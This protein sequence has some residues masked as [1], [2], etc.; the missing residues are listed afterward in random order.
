LVE[1]ALAE[2]ELWIGEMRGVVVGG[3]RLLVVRHEHGVCVYRDRCPHQGHPLSDGT[4][5]DGVLT[6]RLHRHSF[7]AVSGD[8]LNPLRPCLNTVPSRVEA[9]RV[10]VDVPAPR[11]VSP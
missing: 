11:K 3:E 8:G 6:C 9:G 10:L 2:A 1:V 5:V 4:F 7:D